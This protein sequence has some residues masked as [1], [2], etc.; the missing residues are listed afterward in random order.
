MITP[1]QSGSSA[2]VAEW[3]TQLTQNQPVYT[4]WVRLPSLVPPSNYPQIPRPRYSVLF[5]A[6]LR[7]R[8]GNPDKILTRVSRLALPRGIPGSGV[9]G[10]A[11]SRKPRL[12]L[13]LLPLRASAAGIASRQSAITE[14]K[15][16]CG[17]CKSLFFCRLRCVFGLSG[18]RLVPIFRAKK[19]AGDHRR[20]RLCQ[21]FV[22]I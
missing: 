2:S 17:F 10:Y 8:R 9:I 16:G 12:F 6:F 22:R 21:E 4:L 3:Q 11:P 13:L 7:F 15:H 5:H 1:G 19:D 20:Q 18:Y 14:Q